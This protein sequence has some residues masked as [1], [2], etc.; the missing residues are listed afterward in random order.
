MYVWEWNLLEVWALNN[1]NDNCKYILSVRDV[2][3][4]FIHLVPLWTMRGTAVAWG[5]RRYSRILGVPFGCEHIWERIFKHRL[6]RD[7]KTQ[8]H[9]VSGV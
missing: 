7:V 1:F 9:S 6:P 2:L 4:K 8:G 5:I 3:S